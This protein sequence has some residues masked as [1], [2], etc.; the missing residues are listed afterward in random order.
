MEEKIIQSKYKYDK[1]F[2]IYMLKLIP[3]VF[4]LQNLVGA[5][6]LM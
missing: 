2:K 5:V 3:E 1:T 6:C 4:T